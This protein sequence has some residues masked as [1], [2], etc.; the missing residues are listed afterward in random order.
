MVMMDRPSEVKLTTQA[1]IDV[2]AERRRQVDAEGWTPEHD[3]GH[4]GGEIARAAACYALHASGFKADAIMELWPKEW[5][6]RWWKPTDTRRNLVK[7]AALLVA[8]IERLDRSALST[9]AREGGE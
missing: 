9:G 5:G 7:A 1:M 2:I 4:Q 8:E 6:S 3:D